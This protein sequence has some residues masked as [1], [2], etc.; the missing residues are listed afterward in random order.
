MERSMRC[1]IPPR[2]SPSQ[3]WH[4]VQHKKVPQSLSR[5]QKRRIQRQRVVDKRQ[6]IDVSIKTLLEEAM[7]LDKVK[8]G[9]IPSLEKTKFGRKSTEDM[10][11]MSSADEVIDLKAL[12]ISEILISLNC[13]TI[14]LTLPVIFKSK[15]AEEDL[16]EVEGKHPVTEEDEVHGGVTIESFEECRPQKVILEKPF[17]EMTRHIKPLYVRAHLNNGLVSKVLIDNGSVVNVMSLRMMRALGRSTSYLIEAEV[18]VSAFTREVSK[19]LGMLPI[20]IT[21]GSK[22]S[23]SAFFVIDSTTNYNIFLGRNW[24]HANWCVSSS[25]HQFLLFW[26]GNEVELV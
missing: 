22:T 25:L 21:I 5:T 6:F 4:V 11:S 18:V 3:R 17:V 19:T 8:E 26:K 13:S 2:V 9:M 20:D 14:S 10:E 16:V 1:I 7:K 24:I 12:L 15:N 23:L